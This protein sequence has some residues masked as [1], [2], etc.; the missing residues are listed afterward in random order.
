VR[1][2]L[3][4]GIDDHDRDPLPD[5]VLDRAQQG[6]LVEGREHDA[7]HA[8]ADEVLDH[9]DL[10]GPVVLLLRT[11]EDHFDA[12][13]FGGHQRA[14]VDGLPELVSGALGNDGDLRTRQ[15]LGGGGFFRSGAAT[16][17]QTEGQKA[18]RPGPNEVSC[19][20]YI[21]K[22]DRVNF[23]KKDSTDDRRRPRR[24]DRLAAYSMTNERR[25]GLF[26]DR[27]SWSRP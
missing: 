12:E 18:A 7:T 19:A 9:G 15:R 20:E 11:F 14:H 23:P 22:T 6:P 10:L 13:L 24:W 1:V 5:R 8:A 3:Q 4:P 16:A 2:A 27:H 25:S 26:Q 17:D 21:E